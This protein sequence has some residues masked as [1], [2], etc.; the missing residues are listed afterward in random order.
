[1]NGRGERERKNGEAKLFN[2][3]QKSA[4]QDPFGDETP[5][6]QFKREKGRE[7]CRVRD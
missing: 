7:S 6:K 2:P 1:M 5:R 4:R 3:S